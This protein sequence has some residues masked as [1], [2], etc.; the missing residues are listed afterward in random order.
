M[1]CSLTLNLITEVH[2]FALGKWRPSVYTIYDVLRT[3]IM[4]LEIIIQ[5]NLLH[6][7][8]HEGKCT[9]IIHVRYV[10]L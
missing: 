3:L 1:G 9:F 2:I 6:M 10:L 7:A 5:V 4:S 8:K